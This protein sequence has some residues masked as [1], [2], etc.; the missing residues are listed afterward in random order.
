MVFAADTEEYDWEKAVIVL[1]D[2]PF[3]H[4]SV[5]DVLVSN[6]Q[7][8]SLYALTLKHLNADGNVLIF[9]KVIQWITCLKPR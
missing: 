7:I 9:S 4:L 8:L 2:V 5:E 3:S 1:G 6:N